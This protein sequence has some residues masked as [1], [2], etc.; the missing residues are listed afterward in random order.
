M[1]QHWN[2]WHFMHWKVSSCCVCRMRSHCTGLTVKKWKGGQ[3]TPHLSWTGPWCPALHLTCNWMVCGHGWDPTGCSRNVLLSKLAEE[4]H[5]INDPWS[6]E[7]TD[8]ESGEIQ[9]LIQVYPN[10]LALEILLA[11]LWVRSLRLDQLWGFTPFLQGCQNFSGLSQVGNAVGIVFSG[12]ILVFPLLL[13]PRAGSAEA[14][15]SAHCV[16]VSFY[17]PE[18]S[19]RPPLFFFFP[20]SPHIGLRFSWIETENFL[21]IFTWWY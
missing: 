3:G 18:F 1:G 4:S 17:K 6:A 7:N 2:W 20:N 19:A 16:R 15:P 8:E 13:T 10:L 5:V 14:Q 12:G 9:R 11:F 21:Y